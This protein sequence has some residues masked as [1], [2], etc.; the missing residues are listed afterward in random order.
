MQLVNG[1]TPPP[2]WTST[3]D[4][5][6]AGRFTASANWG[7]STY[8]TQ[9]YG[10]DYRYANP[11]AVSDAAWYK[12]NIPATASY[13]VEVWYPA[14]AGYNTTTPYVIATTGGNATVQV[15]Q[16]ANGG[17]WV[18]LGTFSLAAGDYNAVGVS[19]WTSSSGYVIA[20]AVRLTR[21]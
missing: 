9:R 14:V 21:V 3:V 12:F 7:T 8:S 17:R 18:N 5:T 16:Q 10:A 1:T 20:D 4:N 2:S 6:T 15:N 11:Q 19:R 13:R